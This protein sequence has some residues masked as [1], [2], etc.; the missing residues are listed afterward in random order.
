MA[1]R[2]QIKP[3]LGHYKLQ[4]LDKTTYKRAYINLLLKKYKVESVKL[5][6]RLFK[7]GINAAVDDE[8]LPRNRFTKITIRDEKAELLCTRTSINDNFLEAH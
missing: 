7:I 5:F 4:K 6:H 2:L 8:I 1:I 3:L